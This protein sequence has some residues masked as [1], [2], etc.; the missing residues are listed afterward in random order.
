MIARLTGRLLYKADYIIIDVN[1]VGYE[2]FISA[3]SAKELPA[4]GEEVSIRIYTHVREDALQLFGFVAYEE[5]VVFKALIAVNGFGPKLAIQIVSQITP[6]ELAAAVAS[7]D[8]KRLCSL[9]GIGQKKAEYLL[10]E[11]KNKLNG[12]EC[13]S[14]SNNVFSE[15]RSALINMAFETTEIDYA[16]SEITKTLP[17]DRFALGLDKLLPIALRFL[18]GKRG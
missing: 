4:L 16:L 9:R 7:D 5:Y 10:L 15:L 17:E 3:F 13:D 18:T 1:G 6:Q 12:I 2:V 11:L 14:F 8:K